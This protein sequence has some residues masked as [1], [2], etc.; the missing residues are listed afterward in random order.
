MQNS[1]RKVG[2]GIRKINRPI[3]QPAKCIMA[4]QRFSTRLTKQTVAVLSRCLLHKKYS[5]IELLS[6]PTA[7]P[8]HALCM[9]LPNQMPFHVKRYRRRRKY[10]E[11]SWGGCLASVC[12]SSQIH[13]VHTRLSCSVSVIS[14]P[15][16]DKLKPARSLRSV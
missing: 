10:S 1:L 13:R 15:C 8:F 3:L 12:R 14:Q 2:Y 16:D 4:N 11:H 7:A 9:R 5:D 6:Y